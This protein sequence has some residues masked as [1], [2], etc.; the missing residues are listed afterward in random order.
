M[1]R[2]QNFGTGL[3][4]REAG[5]EFEL[6]K[7]QPNRLVRQVEGIALYLDFLTEAP[8]AITGSRMVDDV[9]ASVAPG[10]NRALVAR[11]IV[12]ISGR[13]VYSAPQTCEIAVADNGPLLVLK[14]NAFGGLTGR[15]QGLA[16]WAGTSL[17]HPEGYESCQL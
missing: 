7:E 12:K 2:R 8:P 5:H 1:R 13:D 11:R 10:I 3:I 9:V 16:F 15:R 17:T 4:S 6:D 14:L